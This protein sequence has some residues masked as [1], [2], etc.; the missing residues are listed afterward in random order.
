MATQTY[1]TADGRINKLK[2]EILA[3]AVPVEVLGIT[4][5]KKQMP[6]NNGKTVV[7]RRWRPNGAAAGT[8]GAYNVLIDG[9]NVGTFASDH[10][11]TEGV[12]PTALTL[13]PDDVTANLAQ[14]SCLFAVTDVVTDLYEDDVPAEMKKQTGERMGLVREMIRYGEL[15]ACTNMYYA[16]GN[17]KGTVDETLSINIL[18]R[19]AREMLSEH[20]KQITSVLSASAQFNTSPVEAGFLV[21]CHTDM[22]PAIRDLPG[23][24][25]VSEYAQRKVINENEIGSVERFRF[26]LS[27]E[28]APYLGSDTT[29]RG[30]AVGATGLQSTSSYI[31]NYP[32]I[33]VAED[34]WGDVALRGSDSLDVTWIPPGQKDKNDPLGQRGY[35]G[36]KFY[37]AAKILNAGWMAVIM[38][39]TPDLA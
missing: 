34:A 31:D 33:V 15:K 4:G 22:E 9:S 6:K 12:T 36:A 5:Q 8:S 37:S 11:T 13:T 28:L 10:A 27:P 29:N 19:V 21:F 38:A 23:F 2:G 1:T 7:Y 20:A 17:S 26:I 30:A 35:V 39:G 16:G 24:K 3:H 25:H 32:C 14:Y 18:R